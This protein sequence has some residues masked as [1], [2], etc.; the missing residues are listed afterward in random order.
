[1]LFGLSTLRGA[2]PRIISSL[3]SAEP[4][5]PYHSSARQ[6]TA[7]S[8]VAQ[9]QPLALSSVEAVNLTNQVL[10]MD[11]AYAAPAARGINRR[12]HCLGGTTQLSNYDVSQHGNAVGMRATAN[13]YAAQQHFEDGRAIKL[14][15]ARGAQFEPQT[16]YIDHYPVK[17]AI[18]IA[19]S[20]LTDVQCCL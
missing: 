1:M 6:P 4:A 15:D 16:S 5:L 11:S 10:D 13:S 19:S 14:R 18:C 2:T 20:S 12:C 9:P 8:L 17:V 7:T 3:I